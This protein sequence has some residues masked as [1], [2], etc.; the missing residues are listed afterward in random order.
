MT[1]SHSNKKF[2]SNLY[3]KFD[4]TAR[5]E[6]AVFLRTLGYP[7]VKVPTQELYSAGDII[8][9]DLL[10]K[11]SLVEVE[12]KQVWKTSGKWESNFP[13]LHIPQRKVKSKSKIFVMFNSKLD[14]LA[15]IE[16]NTVLNARV[17][18]KN[19]SNKFNGTKTIGEPFLEIKLSDI[20]IYKKQDSAWVKV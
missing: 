19:T 14:T 4:K 8:V 15:L 7:T 18:K 5:N 10:G 11:E 16:G 2:E 13:T 20:L 6:A 1:L 12:V 17:I 3:N 9:K